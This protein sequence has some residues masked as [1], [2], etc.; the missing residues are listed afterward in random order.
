MSKLFRSYENLKNNDSDMIYLFH[1]GN[2]YIALDSDAIL[3]N[4]LYNMKLT[5]FSNECDKCGFSVNSLSKYIELF[6][7]N[8]IKYHIVDQMDDKS[9]INKIYKLINDFEKKELDINSLELIKKIK[10]IIM[11]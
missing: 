5:K 1:C 10:Q 4:E 3:L 2:F 11:E 6:Q 9:K 8:N 7:K